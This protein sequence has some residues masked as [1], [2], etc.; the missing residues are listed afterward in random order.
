MSSP[1]DFKLGMEKVLKA[2]S[3]G[4]NGSSLEDFPPLAGG[5]HVSASPQ[6]AVVPPSGFVVVD[7][8]S[9]PET[10]RKTNSQP[11]SWRSLFGSNTKSKYFD[12][13]IKNGKKVVCI[14]K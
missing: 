2:S 13:V 3:F 1:T 5:Y 8:P 7:P 6:S 10:T 11:S 12:P 14:S 4:L 9:G